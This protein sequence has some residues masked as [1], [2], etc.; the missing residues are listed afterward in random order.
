MLPAYRNLGAG[1][2]TTVSRD[3]MYASYQNYF[4]D[5]ARLGYVRTPISIE[6]SVIDSTAG[7]FGRWVG[8]RRRV[9]GVQEVVGSYYAAWRHTSEG[10]R[11]QLETFVALS[12][13]GSAQC[14]TLR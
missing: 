5:M 2:L 8:R 9:D 3:S 6:V 1:A 13:T 11:L 14:P 7:E 10:W 12:C 4:T